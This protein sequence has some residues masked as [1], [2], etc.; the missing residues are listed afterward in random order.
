MI[1]TTMVSMNG[2]A[3]RVLDNEVSLCA[4]RPDTWH[5]M[6]MDE[7]AY[8]CMNCFGGMKSFHR[9]RW[10]EAMF[11]H[12]KLA[13]QHPT[14]LER[15]DTWPVPLSLSKPNPRGPASH[16]KTGSFDSRGSRRYVVA[17]RS[18]PPEPVT[19]VIHEADPP[20]AGT[21]S[22]TL[23]PKSD[24]VDLGDALLSAMREPVEPVDEP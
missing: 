19:P 9:K 17:T 16:T 4:N 12:P 23:T 21:D 11:Y 10:Q 13:K 18:N 22:T 5:L 20:S 1:M 7:Y 14:T 15:L 6:A 3:H 24:A 8:P 2:F